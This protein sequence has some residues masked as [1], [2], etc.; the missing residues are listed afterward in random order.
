MAAP[1]AM[2]DMSTS[3]EFPPEDEVDRLFGVTS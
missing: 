3:V 1:A 2:M